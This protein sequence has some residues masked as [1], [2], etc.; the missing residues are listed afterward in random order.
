MVSGLKIKSCDLASSPR[1]WLKSWIP[2]LGPS[3]WSR[4]MRAK[5]SMVT[6][7]SATKMPDRSWEDWDLEG[8]SHFSLLGRFREEKKHELHCRCSLLRQAILCFLMS[9]RI[10]W[11]SSA[12]TPFLRHFITGAERTEPSSLSR[13]I[14]HFVNRLDLLM[15]ELC[16][17]VALRLKNET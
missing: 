15:S 12:S 11:T 13:T 8:E 4:H 14:V 17:T 5:E 3:I 7:I 16:K 10:T 2:Q 9:R 1:T 6:L